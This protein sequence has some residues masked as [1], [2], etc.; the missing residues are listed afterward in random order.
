LAGLSRAEFPILGGRARELKQ[1]GPDAGY[2][3]GL[4]A[5]LAGLAEPRRGTAIRR[6]VPLSERPSG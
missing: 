1:L 4:D 3:L 6:V 5:L 2:R